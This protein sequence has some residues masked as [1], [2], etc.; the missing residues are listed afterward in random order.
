MS[1]PRNK[2]LETLL[3]IL[4]EIHGD[5][6][7]EPESINEET[8]PIGDLLDFE[9]LTS[10]TVTRRFFFSLGVDAEPAFSSVFIDK[11]R[12]LSVG[13]AVDRVMRLNLV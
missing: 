1:L 3:S 12:S 13:E 5:M 8:K 10:V 4:E 6:V 7:D 2:I 11:N 9:S